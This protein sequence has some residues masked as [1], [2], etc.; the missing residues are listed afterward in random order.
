MASLVATCQVARHG[1]LFASANDRV[2]P[3]NGYWRRGAG[4]A[5]QVGRQARHLLCS[6]V[7][8]R[9]P[10]IE[11]PDA[12]NPAPRL[13]RHDDPIRDV[14]PDPMERIAAAIGEF[15]NAQVDPIEFRRHADYWIQALE[16]HNTPNLGGFL[17]FAYRKALP[18]EHHPLVPLI[19]YAFSS[20]PSAHE[21]RSTGKEGANREQVMLRVVRAILAACEP[22]FN[23]GPY[24]RMEAGWSE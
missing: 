22:G 11:H 13:G 21:L 17:G 2:T 7:M 20:F 19:Q 16:L 8:K 24:M 14:P 18:P 3:C 12:G 6:Y 15:E 23:F 5:L 9:P 10:P 1:A 4:L